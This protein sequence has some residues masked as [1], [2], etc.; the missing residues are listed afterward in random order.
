MATDDELQAE[1]FAAV[2]I[3]RLQDDVRQLEEENANLRALL[4]RATDGLAAAHTLLTEIVEAL[5]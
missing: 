5:P 2:T 3:A 4:L 1:E